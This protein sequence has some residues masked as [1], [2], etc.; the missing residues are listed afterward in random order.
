MPYLEF[1]SREGGSADIISLNSGGGGGGAEMTLIRALQSLCWIS[2]PPPFP[3]H[4][5]LLSSELT[6]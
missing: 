2:S 3:L 5:A 1:L 4:T 6:L